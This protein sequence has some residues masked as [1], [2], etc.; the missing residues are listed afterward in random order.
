MH[1][2]RLY[3]ESKGE[4]LDGSFS[5]NEHD[6]NGWVCRKS[7]YYVIE[8]YTGCKDKYGKKIFEGDTVKMQGVI[9]SL[10]PLVAVT[11]VGNVTFVDGQ[12]MCRNDYGWNEPVLMKSRSLEVIGNIHEERND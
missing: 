2:F 8:Q 10:D 6:G 9:E 7:K 5:V 1:E 12:F 4:Y 3:N 11:C